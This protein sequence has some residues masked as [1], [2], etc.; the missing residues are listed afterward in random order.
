MTI[1]AQE[2]NEGNE[3]SEGGH[4]EGGDAGA[5]REGDGEGGDGAERDEGNGG[6]GDGDGG[7]RSNGNEAGNGEQRDVSANYQLVIILYS[8][9]LTK[10]ITVHVD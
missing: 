4:R 1:H 3:A 5:D 6:D 8:F 10:K 7:V 9:I 2:Q